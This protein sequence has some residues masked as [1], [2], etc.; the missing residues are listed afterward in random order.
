[1]KDDTENG[2]ELN[3]LLEEIAE[4]GRLNVLCP[5]VSVGDEDAALASLRV[6]IP[7]IES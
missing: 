4:A 1:M 3:R 6:E 5:D 2:K 7:P